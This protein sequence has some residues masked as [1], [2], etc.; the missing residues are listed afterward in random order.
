MGGIRKL[1]FIGIPR[2][3]AMVGSF[4]FWAK[5]ETVEKDWYIMRSHVENC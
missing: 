4:T 3:S 1:D 2:S 5:I